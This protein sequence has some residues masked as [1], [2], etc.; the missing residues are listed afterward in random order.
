M[1]ESREAIFF[2]WL[3][4]ESECI[5]LTESD[6]RTMADRHRILLYPFINK[7]QYCFYSDDFMEASRLEYLQ[8]MQRVQS[9][10]LFLKR[11][12]RYLSSISAIGIVL[13]GIPLANNYYAS[14]FHR[15]TR[16]VDILIES[17][18]I[19]AVSQWLVSQ[20][21]H[22][23]SDYM[24]FN[25]KQQ[26]DF[27]EQSH[28]FCFYGH[29]AVLPQVIELHW[30]CRSSIDAFSFDPFALDAPLLKTNW[31]CIFTMDHLEQLIYL[32]VH[33]TEHRWY[34]LKWLLDLPVLMQH[35]KFHWNELSKRARELGAWEHLAVSMQLLQKLT[36]KY[37]MEGYGNFINDTAVCKKV[38]SILIALQNSAM[39]ETG[40]A[41]AFRQ[42]FFQASFNRRFRKWTFWKRWLMSPADW[43]RFPLP[44]KFHFLYYFMRPLFWVIRKSWS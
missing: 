8:N 30:R 10:D 35:E 31:D 33:G 13:K 26:A 29:S 32:C 5:D 36:G 39:L 15:H 21:Y 24:Q 34:R 12:N 2:R 20:G 1:M 22:M 43:K 9:T 6:L 44:E 7:H 25:S 16:D 3:L 27:R 38:N 17:G 42:M 4:G 19:M 14:R 37:F 18:N 11:L 23:Q 41:A 40:Y 28:H